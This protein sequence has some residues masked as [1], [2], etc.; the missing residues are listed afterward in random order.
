ML[1]TSVAPDTRTPKHSIFKAWRSHFHQVGMSSHCL[2][3]PA[4]KH[5][6]PSSKKIREHGAP[7]PPVRDVVPANKEAGEEEEGG[8][9]LQRGVGGPGVREY[10]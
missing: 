8:H 6:E 7:L 1:A 3:K 5:S 4:T 10:S 2:G 9:V